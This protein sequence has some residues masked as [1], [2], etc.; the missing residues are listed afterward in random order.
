MAGVGPKTGGKFSQLDCQ[1]FKDLLTSVL[2]LEDSKVFVLFLGQL[3]GG[4]W[5]VKL[6]TDDEIDLSDLFIKHEELAVAPLPSLTQLEV[7]KGEEE[8]GEIKEGETQPET[9]EETEFLGPV[10]PMIVLPE[11][12]VVEGNICYFESPSCFYVCPLPHLDVINHVFEQCQSHHLLGRVAPVP[13]TSCLAPDDE[14]YYRA[15]ILSASPQQGLVSVFLVDYGKSME[16]EVEKLISLPEEFSQVPGLVIKA[17]LRGVKPVGEDW[18]EK[19]KMTAE[20]LMEV[21]SSKVFKMTDLKYVHGECVTNITDVKGED[22]AENM[23]KAEAGVED[24]L[25]GRIY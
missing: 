9:V 5:L 14:V 3:E 13:G 10:L 21:G 18:S 17:R 8:G 25:L 12:E 20:I 22:V 6:K 11:S 24:R 1:T 23:I 4:R 15:E 19:E 16:T 2:S 7:E